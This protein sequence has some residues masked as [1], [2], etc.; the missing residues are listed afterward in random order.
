M[1]IE[2][3]NGHYLFLKGIAPYSSGAIAQPGFEIVHAVLERVLPW[4]EGFERID[5]YWKAIGRDRAALCGIELRC[6]TPYSMDG[7][8][9]F[10]RDYCAVLEAWELY[11]DGVNPVARTNVSPAFEKVREP[12]LHGFSYTVPTK[13]SRGTMVI[14]GGGELD[15]PKLVAEAIVRRGETSEE[16]MREKA[17]YVVDLME[18]R[19]LGLGGSWD[20][21]TAVDIYT[22][23]AVE[24]LV[25]DLVVKRMGEAARH[26]IRWYHARP[27]I[28]EIE[29]EMDMRGVL[30][31][32]VI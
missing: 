8:V 16:A 19:L 9:A 11:V 31:E 23:H 5:S 20:L 21:M 15:S 28:V 10:N 22:V 29:Y 14:A 24:G 13:S 2:N 12:V 6:P 27:P 17:A 25:E 7:F 1:L 30:Q 3:K 18:K 26:G 4:R 32:V